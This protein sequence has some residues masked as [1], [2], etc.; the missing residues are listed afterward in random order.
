VQSR[1][2]EW[3]SLLNGIPGQDSEVHRLWHGFRVHS[4]W[5]AVLPRQVIQER[6]EALQELQRQAGGSP[7]SRITR[8]V[9]GSLVYENGDP[10]KL[11]AVWE[12]DHGSVP[13]HAR[14]AGTVSWVLSARAAGRERL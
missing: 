1:D 14:T 7:W 3:E 9:A 4:G 11:L 12:R 10:D 6:A 5:T 13:A 2:A 8:A